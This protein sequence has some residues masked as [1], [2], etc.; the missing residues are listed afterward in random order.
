V[1]SLLAFLFLSLGAMVIGFDYP[2][3]LAFVGA[4]AAF[5]PLFGGLLTAVFALMLGSLESVTVGLGTAVFTLL[6]FI[7]LEWIIEPRL[8]PRKRRSFLLTI[9][10]I[11]PLF[12]VFGLWGLMVAPLLAAAL[13]ALGG[14][15]YQAYMVQRQTAVQLDELE[16]RY[17]QLAQKVSQSN[18]EG[19]I[20]ELQNLSQRLANLLADSRKIEGRRQL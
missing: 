17:Q 14:Q 15:A 18:H 19:A 8:W 12:E 3:L 6:I 9:V 1:Q 5:V 13:E 20:V 4:L 2:L 7:G 16:A 11:L 10:V